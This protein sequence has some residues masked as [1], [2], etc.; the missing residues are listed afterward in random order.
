MQSS[1]DKTKV[2]KQIC[3]ALKMMYLKGL[4]TPLTGNISVRL[5]NTILMTPSSFVPTIRLKY[6]LNP[7]DLVEVDLNGNVVSGGKPTTELPMHLAI[8]NVC[9]KCNAVVHIHGVYSPLLKSSDLDDLFLDTELKYILK[10]RICFVKELIP[11]THDLANAVVEKVREGCEI[12]HLE[13]HGVVTVSDTLGMALEL[14]ELA[15]V[16]AERT[17]LQKLLSKI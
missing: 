12:I 13:R 14:A 5:G 6:E 3:D 4:I 8:Y 16:I 17:V 7:E 9:S 2:G 10:P 15:E 1:V 11:R